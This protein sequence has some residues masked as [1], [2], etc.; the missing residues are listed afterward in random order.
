MNC[1]VLLEGRHGEYSGAH[2]GVADREPLALRFGQRRFL[3]DQLLHDPL[4]DA[5][6]L[7]QLLVHAAAVG[8]AIR[9]H[10]L[11]VDAAESPD[12]DI[13]A[14]DAGDDAVIAGAVALGL[15]RKLGM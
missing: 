4:V 7:E 15:F 8:V 2:L 1:A 9:L 6:L 5:E 3:F 11:L 14:V 13:T 12:G 10:L